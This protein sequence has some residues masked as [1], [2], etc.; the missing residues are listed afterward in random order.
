M[1]VSAHTYKRPHVCFC[2]SFSLRYQDWQS[3]YYTDKHR[4]FREK[5]RAFMDTEVRPH[6]DE[7]EEAHVQR[8]FELP[9]ELYVGGHG[10][11]CMSFVYFIYLFV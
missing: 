10:K 5:V 1:C 7:W 4:K 8:G 9:M 6:A 3:P 2:C 11:R